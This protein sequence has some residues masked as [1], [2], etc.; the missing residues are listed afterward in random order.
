MMEL[1]IRHMKYISAIV[2]NNFNLTKAA[3]VLLTSQSNLSRLINEFEKDEQVQLFSRRKG[4]ITGLTKVGQD[5]LDD[6]SVA[7][8]AY[9]HTM[10]RL[11]NNAKGHFGVVR[12]GIAPVILSVLFDKVITQFILE[13]PD[14]KIEL[15][16]DGAYDLQQQ[17]VNHD[18]DLAFL[19]SPA[20][21]SQIEE[22][23]VYTDRVGVFFRDD[24]RFAQ[25][26]G[27][28]K[29][30]AIAKEKLVVLDDTFML[31]HQIMNLFSRRHLKPDIL[32]QSRSWD[33]SINMCRQMDVVTI[34]PRPITFN[35][36]PRDIQYRDISPDFKW[37]V[38]I[39][40]L[41][42]RISEK[43]VDYVEDY[44]IHYFRENKIKRL[45]YDNEM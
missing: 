43:L 21:T 35:Y 30:Q 34:L 10:N 3:E 2:E 13:N 31:N 7:I 25:Q 22:K 12:V 6:A 1:D 27:P 9:D 41:K 40:R 24:H 20:T 45:N 19:M 15:H 37:Q 36:Q 8:R 33:L 26:P 32:F 38:S 23:I 18:I 4:R 42:Q 14:V 11:R 28:I 39:C 44:M 17:L 29:V 16:E 5:Y